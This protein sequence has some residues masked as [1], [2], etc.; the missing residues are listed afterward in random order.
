M[1]LAIPSV[2]GGQQGRRNRE[3]DRVILSLLQ[4]RIKAKQALFRE[5]SSGQDFVK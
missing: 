4:H 5:M 2:R 1:P 3:S